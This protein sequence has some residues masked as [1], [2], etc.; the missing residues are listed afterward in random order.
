MSDKELLIMMTSKC[1]D[2]ERQLKEAKKEKK[3]IMRWMK[4]YLDQPNGYRCIGYSD[5]YEMY[6][7]LVKQD[8]NEDIRKQLKE[9]GNG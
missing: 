6:Y 2:L 4:K 3:K 1:A 8:I 7:K 9:K 5:L